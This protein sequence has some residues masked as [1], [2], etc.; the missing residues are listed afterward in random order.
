MVELFQVCSKTAKLLANDHAQK[1][2]PNAKFLELHCFM[3]LCKF[4]AV[5][6]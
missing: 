3:C 4:Y 1:S 5:I 2:Y 6:M